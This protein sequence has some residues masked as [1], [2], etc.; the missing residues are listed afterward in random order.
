L[1]LRIISY[2]MSVAEKASM[3][4]ESFASSKNLMQTRRQ[5]NFYQLTSG[6]FAQT[7]KLFLRKPAV[8]FTWP[9]IYFKICPTDQESTIA[10]H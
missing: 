6:S 10:S 2:F 7:N 4:L 1:F 8:Q 3:L 9:S 5:I